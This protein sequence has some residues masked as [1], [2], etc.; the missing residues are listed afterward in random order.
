MTTVVLYYPRENPFYRKISG[1]RIPA[2]NG[3]KPFPDEPIEILK[4]IEF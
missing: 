1:N 3:H 2:I 4:P